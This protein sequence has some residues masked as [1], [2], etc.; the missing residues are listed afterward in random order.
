VIHNLQFRLMLAFI[1]VIV[2]TVGTASFFFARS[3]WDELQHYEVQNNAVRNARIEYVISR[4][5]SANRK[6]DGIQPIIEQLGTMEE[7]RIV[8]TDSNNLVIADS[9]KDLVGKEYRTSEAGTTLYLPFFVMPNPPSFNPSTGMNSY[10][11]K[12]GIQLGTLYISPQGP[13]SVLT[14]YLTSTINRFLLWGGLLA[15]AIALIITFVLSRHILSPI[16]ALTATAKKLGQGDFSQ[17][18]QIRNQGEVKELA[19]TFNAMASGL[20]HTEKLRRNMVA[21]I[22]HEL[23]TPLSNVAGYLEAIQDDIIKPDKATI[24]SLNEEVGLLSRLVDDL[25]ELALA[26][27]G[28]LKLMRQP[29]DLTLLIEQSIKAAQTKAR[30]KSLYVSTDLPDT[31]PPVNIDYQRISQ[32]LRNLLANAIAHT[33]DGGK[34]MISAR[35]EGNNIKV[36]VQDTGEGIPAADLPNMFERFYR[37]DKSRTRNRGGSGLGLT[38]AKRLVEAHGGAIGVQSEQEKGSTFYFTLPFDSSSLE[39][40]T[41]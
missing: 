26:D 1:F 12:T 14:I 10:S 24:S 27:A 30:E 15:I 40:P 39:A 34:I 29:E 17:R 23:R 8:L 5:F 4:F 37:V 11:A 7:K 35:A 6:W 41:N 32:V 20:E 22:A 33:A 21:D 3:V 31:L 18:V 25:Q 2:V 28:E 9:Q 16:K 38:I 19:Q 13:G 36:S